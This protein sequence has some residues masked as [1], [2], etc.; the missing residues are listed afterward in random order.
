MMISECVFDLRKI[1]DA[2]Y[3]SVTAQLMMGEILQIILI[4]KTLHLL[5]KANNPMLFFHHLRTEETSALRMQY[6]PWELLAN[7]CF[8]P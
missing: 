8:N 5:G 3:L 6:L 1:T 4:D 7:I 2:A